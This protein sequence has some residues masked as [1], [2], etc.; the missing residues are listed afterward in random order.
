MNFVSKA[1][2]LITMASG[3]AG[4]AIAAPQSY[5]LTAQNIRA[6]VVILDSAQSGSIYNALLGQSV[7]PFALYNLDSALNVKPAGW[8]I[9][10]PHAPGIVT[11]DIVQRWQALGGT[12]PTYLAPIAKQDAEYW[13]VH[14]DT[15]SDLQLSDYDFLLL[16][17]FH[18]GTLNN[19][20]R[21]K[22]TKFVDQGGI[23]WVDTA[24]IS[25]TDSY[26]GFPD[27]FSIYNAGNNAAVS[28]NPF[29]PI[30]NSPY[31]LTSS[32]LN[33]VS[34]PGVLGNY[35]G[36]GAST[37]NGADLVDANA[38]YRYL[39]ITYFT[40]TAMISVSHEGDGL[41][42]ATT[43]GPSVLLGGGTANNQY[44]AAS[45]GL[46]TAGISA[47]K[48]AINLISAKGDFAQPNGGA[49]GTGSN[50]IDV[51]AP[52][53]SRWSDDTSAVGTNTVGPPTVSTSPVIYKGV[54]VVSGQNNIYVYDS[55]PASDLDGDGDPDD[56]IYDS[57]GNLDNALRDYSIGVPYDLIWASST[58]SG[59]ISSPVCAQV[60]DGA[61]GVTDIVTVIDGQ[62]NFHAFNLFPRTNGNLIGTL[63]PGASGFNGMS[64]IY[65]VQCPVNGFSTSDG[66]PSAQGTITPNPPTISGDLAFIVASGSNTGNGP[67]GAAWIVDLS[68][69]KILTSDG[70]NWAIGNTTAN[71]S[72]IDFLP[73]Y[74]AAATV[75]DIPIQDNSGGYDRV[76]YAPGTVGSN[77]APGFD[78]LWFGVKGESPLTYSVSGGTLTISTRASGAGLW[79]FNSGG[80]TALLAL[81]PRVTFLNSNGEAI[82]TSRYISGAPT[83]QSPGDL[84]YAV[85][86]AGDFSGTTPVVAGIRID[87]TIDWA[88]QSDQPRTGIQRGEI[89][90]PTPSEGGTVTTTHRVLGPIAMTGDGTVVMTTGDPTLGKLNGVPAP[91]GDSGGS[92]WWLRE[93]QGRGSFRVTGRYSL[94][95]AY[96][97]QSTPNATAEGPVFEDA[98]PL[99]S[100]IPVPG[101]TSPLANWHWTGAP[102]VSGAQVIATAYATKGFIPVT[103]V[104][105]FAAEPPTA[106]F[107]GLETG[108]LAN[109]FNLVQPDFERSSVGSLAAPTGPDTES[110]ISPSAS[111]VFYDTTSGTLS[112]PSLAPPLTGVATISE[113]L[114]MSAPLLI[115]QGEQST[116]YQPELNAGTWSPL[117]WFCV[118]DG[119]IAEGRAL[120]TGNTIFSAGSSAI[121]SILAGNGSPSQSAVIGAMDASISQ[122]DPFMVQNDSKLSAEFK[123][124]PP[125]Y[126]AWQSQVEVVQTIGSSGTF[127][128]DGHIKMPSS[129]GIASFSDYQ[130][131]LIQQTLGTSGVAYGIVGGGNNL[132]SWGDQGVYGLSRADFTICDSGRYLRTDSNG[133]PIF[134]SNATLN[135]GP[136]GGSPV[137]NVKPLVRPTRAYPLS[138]F[139]T[140]VVDSGSSRVIRTDNSG[141]EVRA[142]TNFIPD[143]QYKPG[144][145]TANEPR[146]LNS[147]QDAITYSNYVYRSA[148]QQVYQ[149]QTEEYW[150]HY[151]IADTGNNRL[152]ELIDRF[153]IVN[154]RVGPII[155]VSEPDPNAT[156]TTVGGSVATITVPQVGV[157][158]WQSP[159]QVSGR[160][161]SYNSVCRTFLWSG[162][163]AG[164]YVYVAGIGNTQPALTSAALDTPP[165]NLTQGQ[166]STGNC[167]VVIFDPA[168]PGGVQIYN[169]FDRQ[170]LTGTPF[171]DQSANNGNGAFD[172]SQPQINTPAATVPIGGLRSVFV[173]SI[174]P[175]AGGN[176]E[177]AIMIAEASGVYEFDVDPTVQ[178]KSGDLVG[179]TSG[180]LGTPVWFINNAAYTSL[181]GGGNGN[182][183]FQFTPAYAKRLDSGDVLIVNSYVGKNLARNAYN[184]EVVMLNG[185]SGGTGGTF[186]VGAQ[187]LGFTP[188]SIKFNLPQGSSG[189]RSL[190]APIFADRR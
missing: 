7:A 36:I 129:V 190:I 143:Y 110:N 40:N 158:L 45:P 147:P 59:P 153:S 131:R 29:E 159:S 39:G 35:V 132:A 28:S 154:G 139:E 136:G 41:I 126:R 27:A 83:Q 128:P 106:S 25:Q 160:N 182:N 1:F 102:V 109:S 22:L 130:T 38:V 120:V 60:A 9:Y 49:R 186:A 84:V 150:V 8:N 142:I 167:G 89:T 145:Y 73:G 61:G 114:N 52:V 169:S 172:T 2:A 62:G 133:N 157:L 31:Q 30:L 164:R 121:P 117:H 69:G 76:I 107:V 55:T 47:A 67:A 151:L 85:S 80:S 125:P 48:F 91:T 77:L 26:N 32:D 127:S 187:N 34:G 97:L 68:T 111:N 100:L 42:V 134:A 10:N 108:A 171:W 5:S 183:A 3:L 155:S 103:V 92:L 96:H 119:T 63:K 116:V 166:S 43:M 20:E 156:P 94:Y 175:A 4:A 57:N 54:T 16:N 81:A 53:L 137:G 140:L 189:V 105:A 177:L 179:A 152:V 70:L 170:S 82:S 98:D 66:I 113:C 87:Y 56:G 184:G 23:L 15:T 161:F 50:P 146:T 90:F 86:N 14:L 112:L 13:S 124:T 11:N 138:N 115:Q 93:D 178:N 181:H 101:I 19:L 21:A 165:V 72:N 64:P 17:P 188:Q 144:G 104:M 75:G 163:D 51:T 118:F 180:D 71:P 12:V 33:A 74:T 95:S 185:G 141:S 58:M 162:T 78:S 176:G 79:I 44:V 168:S 149:Q 148:G 37:T 99:Q 65:S 88:R 173:R 18:L 24:G 46:G 6:G 174:L 122:N 123:G 135:T